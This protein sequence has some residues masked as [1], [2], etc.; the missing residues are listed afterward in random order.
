MLTCTFRW[1]KDKIIMQRAEQV[2]FC[3]LQG[4]WPTPKLLNSMMNLSAV[5]QH[6]ASGSGAMDSPHRTESPASDYR[7]ATKSAKMRGRPQA[8]TPQINYQPQNSTL[9]AINSSQQARVT[10]SLVARVAKISKNI[11][12]ERLFLNSRVIIAVKRSFK[13]NL[14]FSQSKSTE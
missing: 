12:Y 14:S 4:E 3:I 11:H 1:P 2:C 9:D 13:A 5:G 6:G 10:T 7:S 8:R